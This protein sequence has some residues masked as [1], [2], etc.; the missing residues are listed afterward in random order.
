MI[1]LKSGLF[2]NKSIFE[3]I[4]PGSICAVF[5]IYIFTAIAVAYNLAIN[6]IPFAFFVSDCTMYATQHHVVNW[7]VAFVAATDGERT[8]CMCE[9]QYIMSYISAEYFYVQTLTFTCTYI[10]NAYIFISDFILVL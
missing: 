5:D 9:C 3:G 4:N 10:R 8:F 6:D 7:D 2:I 1:S